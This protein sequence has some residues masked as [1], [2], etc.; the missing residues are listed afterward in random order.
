MNISNKVLTCREPSC[1]GNVQLQVNFTLGRYINTH[2]RI[3]VYTYIEKQLNNLIS[4]RIEKEEE[5]SIDLA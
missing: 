2:I 5:K 4:I 1:L 3:Y